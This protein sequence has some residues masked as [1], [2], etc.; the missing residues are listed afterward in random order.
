MAEV[1]ERVERGELKRVIVNLPPRSTKSKFSSV[2]FPAWYLGKHPDAK[3]MGASHTASL[4]LDFGR[5]LRNL[6]NSEEYRRIFSVTL[7]V[8]AAPPGAGTPMPAASISPE[9]AALLPAAAVASSSSMTRI[10]SM[11]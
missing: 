2:L 3:V 4:S 7:A 9:R 8:D 1:F 11:R 10:P 6:I 5:E